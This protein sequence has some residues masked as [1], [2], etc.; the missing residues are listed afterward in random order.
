MP[1]DM[2]LRSTTTRRETNM[3]DMHHKCT[4]IAKYF[5]LDNQCD[6]LVE[7][8]AELIQAVNKRKRAKKDPVQHALAMRNLV[9][10]IAD[11]ELMLDQVKFL[12]NITED[13]LNENKQLKI[14]RTLDRIAKSKK[15]A[16]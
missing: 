5:G 9:E 7:E 3:E 11:V 15:E 2:H 4:E 12:L 10:E 1:Q 16:C 14:D 13:E 8:C 6:Q